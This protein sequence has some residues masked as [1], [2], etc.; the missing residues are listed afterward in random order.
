MEIKKQCQYCGC[1]FIAHKMTTIYCSPSC[2]N[3]DYKRKIR[4]KQI[5]EYQAQH[6]TSP[7]RVVKPTSTA[8]EFLTPTEGA[9]LLGI[10]RATFYR[11][12]REG[13]IK[14]LVPILISW[15]VKQRS[16]TP[17]NVSLFGHSSSRIAEWRS[18]HIHRW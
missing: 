2:N 1:S 17:T 9:K 4:E 3:K 12:M 11:N 13:T 15:Y 14:A 8:K 7:P 18:I 6:P 5:A 10:S 16:I